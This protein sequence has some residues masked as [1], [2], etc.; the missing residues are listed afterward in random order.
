LRK[1]ALDASEPFFGVI[2]FNHGENQ[3]AA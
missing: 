3:I 1:H 2:G